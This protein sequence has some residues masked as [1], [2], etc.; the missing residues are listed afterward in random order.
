MAEV[1]KDD[2]IRL[3]KEAGWQYADGDDGYEPLWAFARLVVANTPPQSSM[4]WQEGYAAGRQREWVGLT[5]DEI[6]RIASKLNGENWKI[7]VQAIEAK[8]RE[9]NQ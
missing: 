3:A 6:Y 5:E 7:V 4:A 9:K 1:T 8:L 2:M